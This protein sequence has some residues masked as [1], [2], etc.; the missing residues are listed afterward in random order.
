MLEVLSR[1]AGD[2]TGL[3]LRSLSS[4]VLLGLALT[5]CS[6]LGDDGSYG[7]AGNAGSSGS[8]GGSLF[9]SGLTGD[10]EIDPDSSCATTTLQAERIPLD[11][12]FMVDTSGSMDGPK[13]A[14]LKSGLSSFL[15]APDSAALGVTGQRFP[16]GGLNETCESTAYGTPAVPWAIL[17]DSQLSGWISSLTAEGYTPSVPALR[18]A[19]DACKSRMVAEPGRKCAVVFV[20]D[21]EPEGNCPPASISAKQPLGEIAA[22]AFE[23]GIPVF[24]VSFYGISSVGQTI[25]IAIAQ[26]GGTQVPFAIKEGSVQQDF[27]DA[28]AEARGTALGCEYQMPTTDAGVVNPNLVKV[29]YTPGAGGESQT[30]PRKDSLA[31]C[32]SQAGWAYD[33]NDNPTKLVMCPSTCDVMRADAKGK[34]EILLG[35]SSSQR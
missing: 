16:I 24:A 5:A 17:P 30:V 20:S 6:A 14:L 10:G 19:V 27:V 11:M 13:L 28:L 23:Q 21:G 31:A 2:P 32:G 8:G 33:N 4:A 9:D 3:S 35:C 7:N 25:L 15:Q 26:E 34:V 18:G 12:Y 29:G 22:E 1:D